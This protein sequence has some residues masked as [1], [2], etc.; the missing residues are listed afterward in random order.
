MYQGTLEDG[1]LQGKGREYDEA[2]LLRY[3]GNFVDGQRSGDGCLYEAG[4]LVYE[5]QFSRRRDQRHRNCL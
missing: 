3:E 2:R 1:L 4:V 5:G